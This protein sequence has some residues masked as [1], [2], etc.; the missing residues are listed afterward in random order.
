[1]LSHVQLAFLGTPSNILNKQT[2]FVLRAFSARFAKDLIEQQV[3]VPVDLDQTN[4]RCAKS[5]GIQVR[6]C[7]TFKKQGA[8]DFRKDA[9][10]RLKN[11]DGSPRCKIAP[12][13]FLVEI[14]PEFLCGLLE[15][16]W[17]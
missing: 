2:V 10:R 11:S 17:R 6:I 13:L 12:T 16:H 7:V 5:Q 15:V 8:K 3:H 4:E 14:D 1:M 9:E